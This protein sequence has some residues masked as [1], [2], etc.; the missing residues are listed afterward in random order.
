METPGL[1]EK[2][3]L[4]ELRKFGLVVGSIFGL[5]G[6]WPALILGNAFRFWALVLA[7]VLIVPA[8]VVPR[9]LAQIHQSWMGVA[10]V[11]AWINTRMIMGIAFVVFFIP[12][13]LVMRL[14]GK[15][16]MRRRF[17]RDLETYRV[18]KYSRPASHMNRQF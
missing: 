6:I 13:G 1:Q 14:V 9:S 12:F 16:P 10:H 7:V 4:Q 3:S 8:L 15:D 18:K 2:A 11:L 17:E 5:V